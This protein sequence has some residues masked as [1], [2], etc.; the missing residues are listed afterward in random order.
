MGTTWRRKEVIGDCT[1][2]LGDMRDVLPALPE[3]ADLV[4]TDAPYKLT[5]GG[6]KNQSMGG[7]FAKE[8]YD[9][10]GDLMESLPWHEMGGPINRACKANADVYV[11]CNDK[12]VSN[13]EIAFRG[14]DLKMH[15][16]L[17]WD[18][19]TATRSPFY[20]KNQEYILYLWK[21]D[22]KRPNYGGAKQ[23][24]ECAR[25]KGLDW[26]PTPKPTPLMALYVLQSSQPGDLVLDPF[27][28]AGASALASLAFG[29]RAVMVEINETYF[30]LA[31][32][33]IEAAQRDGFQQIRADWDRCRAHNKINGLQYAA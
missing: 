26:H 8:N 25:P 27:M 24:F 4:V 13:A 30:D 6:H 23:K 28:G 18:K 33:R 1:L 7:K 29:R 14:A 11:M 12:H 19:G 3:K 10:S 2:Y 17:S 21:G 15:N 32:A 16:L 31:C 22:A 20:M 9:N 5:S